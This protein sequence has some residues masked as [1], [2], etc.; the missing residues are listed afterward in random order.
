MENEFAC[1]RSRRTGNKVQ[2]MNI[3]ADKGEAEEC[4]GMQATAGQ[5]WPADTPSTD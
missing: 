1:M 4:W 2:N 3:R 5:R